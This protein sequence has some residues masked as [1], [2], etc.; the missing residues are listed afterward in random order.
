[1]SKVV[2]IDS[3]KKPCPYC[4]KLP[5]CP[6][7]TCPRIRAVWHCERDDEWQVEFHENWQPRDDEPDDAA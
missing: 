5:A 7:F 2:G 6:D 3:G 4:S 1:V